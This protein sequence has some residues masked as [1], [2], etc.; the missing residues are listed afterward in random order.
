MTA[1]VDRIELASGRPDG[2]PRAI[3]RVPEVLA[4]CAATP[5]GASLAQLSNELE[6]PKTSLHRL[7]RTL[8]S[9]AYLQ[10]SGDTYRLGPESFRLAH[11]IGQYQPSKLYPACAKPVLEWLA[12]ETH[13]SIVLGVLSEDRTSMVYVDSI[14]STAQLRFTV[15][16]GSRRAL[17][18]GAA[19]RVVLA[20]LPEEEQRRYIDTTELVPDTPRTP[21]REQ[22]PGILQT[23]RE[24]AIL[25]DVNGNFAGASA[26]SAPIF[27][28]EGQVFSAVTIA[29]PTDRMVSNKT[30]FEA[31]ARTAAARISSLLGYNGVYPP[32]K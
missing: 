19:G 25:F 32:G 5:D 4:A 20:F 7:L 21:T 3:L 14:D 13:E 11:L 30:R 16:I 31:L 6:L 18:R 27:N 12:Q 1:N 17:Y 8:E 9:G 23:A 24:Q 22:L 26:M 29:G 28:N 10:R 15:P 2:Q